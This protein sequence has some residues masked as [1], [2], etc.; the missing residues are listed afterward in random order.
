MTKDMT[1]FPSIKDKRFALCV[2][3]IKSGK[4]QKEILCIVVDGGLIS[5][6]IEPDGAGYC[7]LC[8]GVDKFQLV[9]NFEE[10]RKTIESPKK[11]GWNGVK[12]CGPSGEAFKWDKRETK[13][14]CKE[15]MKRDGRIKIDLNNI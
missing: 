8:P 14:V 9:A 2:L 11:N 5:E 3:Q 12:V 1:K 6:I 13:K 7:L 15:I 4:I 10:F